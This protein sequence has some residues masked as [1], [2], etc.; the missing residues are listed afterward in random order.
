MAVDERLRRLAPIV[1]GG[2]GFGL[3]VLRMRGGGASERELVVAGLIGGAA[4]LVAYA[5]ATVRGSVGVIAGVVGGLWLAAT[6]AAAG[7]VMPA[8][9]AALA[10]LVCLCVARADK[11]EA[12]PAMFTAPV[13]VAL[14]IFEPRAWALAGVAAAAVAWRNDGRRRFI[15]AAPA[16]AALVG[17][18]LVATKHAPTWARHVSATNPN[19]WL[20]ATVDALGPVAIVVAS[21]G[22]AL[23]LSDRRM[24]W[25]AAA[26]A[27]ALAAALPLTY[28]SPSIALV[29][30]AMALGVALASIAA[31]VG[32]MR[33]QALVG[34]ALAAILVTQ[35]VI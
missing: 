15:A 26:I 25:T 6:A 2:A 4:A 8:V 5:I 11:L 21:L 29:G 7:G 27:G 3:A 23:G 10:A 35:F 16:I 13:A 20:E 17:G 18:V 19:L 28:E 1:T 24:R 14:V 9:A 34:A 32:R 12:P 33:N 31:R 30:V 22:V